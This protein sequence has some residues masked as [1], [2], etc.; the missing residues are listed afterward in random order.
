[1]PL[2][3]IPAD[4]S[5]LPVPTAA[6]RSGGRAAAGA[7]E[8]QLCAIVAA[9][10]KLPEVGADNNFFDVGM[11]SIRSVQLVSRAKKAGLKVSVADVFANQSVSSLARAVARKESR[12]QVLDVFRSVEDDPFATMV[13]LRS[14][15]DLPPLFCV[16]SGTGFSLP[17]V[18]LAAHVGEGHPIY[19]IQDPSVME[20]AP[21]PADL[22][23]LADDYVR[24]IREVWPD[25]PY[26]LL[27]WS[28]G[29]VLVH[30]MAVRLRREG[31]EVRLVA[32]LDAYPRTGIEDRGGD[33]EMFA[34]VLRMIGREP[35]GPITAG[36]LAE[37]LQADDGPLA[38]LGTERTMA[39]LDVMRSH[40][41]LL[42]KHVPVEYDGEMQLFVAT[43]GLSA[44]EIAKRAA[45]WDGLAQTAVHQVGFKH[46][47]LMRPEA[48]ALIG[49]VIAE[50]LAR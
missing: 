42:G 39:M 33:Q 5:A 15:G 28:F 23:A 3:E 44:D 13:R 8:E 27:G 4:H 46:D 50:V 35:Q 12:R 11:D 47:D 25:G 7:L 14:G 1:V 9:V 26:H 31:A 19:G 16:H 32:N 29:G 49:K 43:E 22:G 24:R 48:L 21:L 18:G 37:I 17:Y 41:T 6:Q 30:E 45:R 20:L 34:W 40:T 10:L 38:G 2:D 36:Q